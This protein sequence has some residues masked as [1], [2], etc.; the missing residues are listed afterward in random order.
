MKQKNTGNTID[1]IPATNKNYNTLNVLL[2]AGI[3]GIA[4]IVSSFNPWV[5]AA[6]YI[7]FDIIS[8]GLNKIIIRFNVK[9]LDKY[10]DL[11][12]KR[13]TTREKSPNSTSYQKYWEYEV[14]LIQKAI[15]KAKKEHQQHEEKLKILSKKENAQE[16][17]FNNSFARL[18]EYNYMHEN[19]NQALYEKLINKTQK[20][21]K[22]IGENK[23]CYI[24]LDTTFKTYVDELMLLLDAFKGLGKDISQ[25]D[26]DK[27]D[28]L[29]K[30]FITFL[31]KTIDKIVQH[32]QVVIDTSYDVLKKNL[33]NE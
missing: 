10:E 19:I 18:L 13:I 33:E 11:Y 21:Q 2:N 23:E 26:I 22:L 29:L 27:C 28:D 25:E 9:K 17:V 15:D 3:C 16:D 12:K 24:Y 8:V 6:T 14:A 20:V 4:C 5:I 30:T 1:Y 32:N 7:V 31:E